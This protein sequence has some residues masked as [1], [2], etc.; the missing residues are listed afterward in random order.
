MNKQEYDQFISF[1]PH[2]ITLRQQK[3]RQAVALCKEKGYHT[4][5]LYKMPKKRLQ[6]VVY[7]LKGGVSN[8]KKARD[9]I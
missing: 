2:H 3:L 6:A 1:I 7:K 4:A 9:Y 5:K 8:D